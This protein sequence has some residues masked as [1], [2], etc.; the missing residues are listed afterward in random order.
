MYY[1]QT[2]LNQLTIDSDNIKSLKEKAVAADKT[3]IL[4]SYCSSNKDIF[5]EN[6]LIITLDK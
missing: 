5:N 2:T 3:I 1:Q 4:I 6:Y